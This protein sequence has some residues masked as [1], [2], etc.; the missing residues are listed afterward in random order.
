MTPRSIALGWL[1]HG[2]LLVVLALLLAPM[3]DQVASEAW[4]DAMGMV[5]AGALVPP[6]Q[7]LMP[8]LA[9]Q[10]LAIGGVGLACVAAALLALHRG[11]SGPLQAIAAVHLI[12][13][14]LATWWTRRQVEAV[15]PA[16][17]GEQVAEWLTTLLGMAA[18]VIGMRIVHRARRGAA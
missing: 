12:L 10:D 16:S 11:W 17:L 7:A 9:A 18:I 15:W 3:A 14:P 1:V 5:G 2:G 4:V 8:A 13:L 6:M